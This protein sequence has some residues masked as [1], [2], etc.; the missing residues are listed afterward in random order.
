MVI[1]WV[2][3]AA[4][5]FAAGWPTGIS[6]ELFLAVGTS[7]IPLFLASVGVGLE[8]VVV[9]CWES[10]NTAWPAALA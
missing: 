5:E 4:E 2:V 10:A 7:E 1:F 9:Y 3:G 6:T 8:V